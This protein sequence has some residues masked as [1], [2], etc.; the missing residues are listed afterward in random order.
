M[1]KLLIAFAGVSLLVTGCLTSYKDLQMQSDVERLKREVARLKKGG[2][3]QRQ[4]NDV[5]KRLAD[6]RG[7]RGFVFDDERHD[8]FRQGEHPGRL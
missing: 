1:H 4:L 2:G 6:V 7:S 8:G 3:N 5:R